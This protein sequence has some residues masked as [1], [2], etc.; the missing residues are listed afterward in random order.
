MKIYNTV[1]RAV[2]DRDVEK[3]S[4]LVDQIGISGV[5]MAAQM[6]CENRAKAATGGKEYDAE[7]R[8]FW[9]DNSSACTVASEQVTDL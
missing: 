9:W 8:D 7:A 2:D 6:A 5:L 1:V 3:I 4:R